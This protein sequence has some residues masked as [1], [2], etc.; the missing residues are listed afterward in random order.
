MVDRGQ[1]LTLEAIIAAIL[2]LTA[3]SFA[4]QMT[5]VTPLSA[6][7]SNQ[8]LENQ[9]QSTANGLLASTAENGELKEAVLSWNT[10]AGQFHGANPPE[11]EVFY[12]TAPDN[13]FGDELARTFGDRNVAYNVIIYHYFPTDD[14]VGSTRM[15]NQGE[16]SDNAVSASRTIVLDDDARIRNGTDSP[17]KT[18][19][20][21]DSEFYIFDAG[22]AGDTDYPHYNT[23]RVEVVAW[24]I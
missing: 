5:A 8:H 21:A 24:R 6:S 9:L 10:T 14:T 23:V 15:V 7:T 13:A 19:G 2:L 12:T 17:S 20:E 22:E 4:L 11:G 3:V 18:V 16:P 1:A